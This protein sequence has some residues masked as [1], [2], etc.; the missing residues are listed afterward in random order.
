MAVPMG[1]RFGPTG[2]YPS[3]PPISIQLVDSSIVE[4]EISVDI[5]EY[6]ELSPYTGGA[7][8]RAAGGVRRQP[9]FMLC[10]YF[11]KLGG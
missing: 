7:E 6:L 10:C 3:P 1:E 8:E 11:S 5:G 2:I 4:F 9:C